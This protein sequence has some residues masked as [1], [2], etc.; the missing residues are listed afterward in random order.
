MAKH[1]H[2][3][4]LNSF[5]HKREYKNRQLLEEDCLEIVYR[6]LETGKKG[7][8]T[9]KKPR[10]SYYQLT[11]EAE[12]KSRFYRD[13]VPKKDVVPRVSYYAD[14]LMDLK[15]YTE[16]AYND[17][18]VDLGMGGRPLKSLHQVPIFYSSD[19]DIEDYYKGKFLDTYDSSGY[20]LT[21]GYFD[22]EVDIK[23][24]KGF[25]DQNEA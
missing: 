5:Y 20:Y 14:L 11:E 13:Y 6:N 12:K 8:M 23:G 17:F 24:H 15:Y 4:F 1:N 25:P 22:I 21:K 18:K 16:H 9:N 2:Y 19:I 7:I 3:Q 10:I